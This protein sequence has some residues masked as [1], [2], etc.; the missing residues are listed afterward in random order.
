[1]VPIRKTRLR[2]ILSDNIPINGMQIAVTTVATVT[3]FKAVVLE[4]PCVSVA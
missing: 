4:K 2:P 3:T 1:M